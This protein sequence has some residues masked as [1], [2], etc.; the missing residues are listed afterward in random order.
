[1]SNSPF[2]TIWQVD[3]GEEISTR[4]PALLAD[5]VVIPLATGLAWVE[6]ATG[7]VLH[8]EH[9]KLQVMGVVPFGS[10]VVALRQDRDDALVDAYDV[11]G[12]RRWHTK[13]PL[14]V[15]S[16]DLKV[17]GDRVLIVGSGA[18][19][20]QAAFLDS[21]GHDIER[22][23]LVSPDVQTYRGEVYCAAATPVDG[24]RGVMRLD[25]AGP[26]LLLE[27][28]AYS[29]ALEGDTC[30]VDTWDG[31]AAHSE[32]VAFPIEGGPERWRVAGGPNS[33]LVPR[34]GLLAHLETADHGPLVVL[35]RLT[36]G[37]VVWRSAAVGKDEPGL[38]G[39]CNGVA[40]ST[41][42]GVIVWL[43]GRELVRLASADGAL[44]GRAPIQS[45]PPAGVTVTPEGLL[46]RY[47]RQ[48]SLLA[49]ERTPR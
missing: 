33:H 38:F 15:G 5:R 3:L 11:A 27:V 19:G 41:D 49:L 36:D 21:E 23:P 7:R 29:W 43:H 34:G 4:A 24:H 47:D 14:G 32:L 37:H 6:L 9:G 26:H 30:V 20:L 39:R 48:L 2:V 31:W 16:E 13:L 12:G 22:W 35:R 17:L 25:R 28:A 46:V 10:G 45:L 44:R 40:T 8:A 42:A 18:D 1:M